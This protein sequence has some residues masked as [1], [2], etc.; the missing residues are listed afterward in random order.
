MNALKWLALIT[1]IVVISLVLFGTLKGTAAVR[2]WLET[3]QIFFDVGAAFA[4]TVMGLVLAYEGNRISE[5]QTLLAER[6]TTL[7]ERQTLVAEEE[8]R[9]RLRFSIEL[10][11]PEF[12]EALI[13]TN[14][15]GALLS[16]NFMQ[17]SFLRIALQPLMEPAG[18]EILWVPFYFFIHRDV[19]GN[20]KDDIFRLYSKHPAL[21]GPD[22]F[23]P[24]PHST[25]EVHEF[26]KQLR[27]YAP[28]CGFRLASL[29]LRHYVELHYEWP[30]GNE[31]ATFW[32]R[33]PDWGGLP[34]QRLAES[35]FFS[36]PK[37]Y[38][39]HTSVSN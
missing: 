29:E 8:L 11:S 20:L 7:A 1:S 17:V 31:V 36:D 27:E 30:L 14:E 28:D 13:A 22:R 4:L 34:A 21:P 24:A 26:E 5:R 16:Y 32:V 23:W 39:H 6:Q 9:P 2:E 33:V 19:S 15:G 10:G 18:Q 12:G 35:N 25:E 37:R 38:R 3:N